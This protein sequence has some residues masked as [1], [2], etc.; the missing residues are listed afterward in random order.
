MPF[1]RKCGRRL[2]LY[3][4]S[5]P[6]CG[7]ST[8]AAIIKIKKASAAHTYKAP[9]KTKIAKIVIPKVETTVSVRPVIPTKPV[10]ATAPA[11]NGTPS[12][13]IHQAMPNIPAEKPE[14]EIKQS[15]LSLEEDIITNPHDYETQTFD[16]DLK[17]PH[18]HFFAAGS[19]LP[20]SKGNAYCPICGEQLRKP[21]RKKQR[22]YGRF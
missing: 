12:K 20:V 15:N 22:R 10:K 4:E 17:C 6:D 14:H 2:P 21:E 3:S 8:T 18:S 11:K 19:T 7:T 16:F 9:P 5:C 1:C 13:P